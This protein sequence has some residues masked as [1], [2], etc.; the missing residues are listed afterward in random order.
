MEPARSVHSDFPPICYSKNSNTGLL[1]PPGDIPPELTA[2]MIEK[3][4]VSWLE[5][6]RQ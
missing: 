1:H 4:R 6:W 5:A 2:E 3:I